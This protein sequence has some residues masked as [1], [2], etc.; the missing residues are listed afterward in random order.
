MQ[1]IK[2]LVSVISLSLH[3]AKTSSNNIVYNKALIINSAWLIITQKILIID[4]VDII[5]Q[6]P[7]MSHLRSLRK[8]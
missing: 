8:E 3:S 7:F 2:V 4:I 6:Q 1:V 5:N